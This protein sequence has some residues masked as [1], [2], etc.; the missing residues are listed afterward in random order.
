MVQLVVLL[1]I[2]GV[3]TFL[4]GAALGASG[5]RYF[6]KRD[7]VRLEQWADEV[8]AAKEAAVRRFK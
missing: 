4:V 6:L 3:V 8:R 5:Y 2:V 7:P 1:V